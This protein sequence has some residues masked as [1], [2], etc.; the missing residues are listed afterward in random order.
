MKRG[1]PYFTCM[2]AAGNTILVIVGIVSPGSRWRWSIA[3]CGY[4][5]LRRYA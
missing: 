4:C 5:G 1:H 2:A 3:A